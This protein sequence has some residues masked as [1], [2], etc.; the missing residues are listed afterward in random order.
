MVLLA[1]TPHARGD[2]MFET[3]SAFATVG[4]STGTTPLLSA[5]SQLI[6]IGLMILGRVGPITLFAALVLRE[7]DRL[8]HFPD[9]RPI[10]G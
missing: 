1:T 4:L 5:S 7:R 2:L 10:I 3:I 6:I 9:E 8:Y